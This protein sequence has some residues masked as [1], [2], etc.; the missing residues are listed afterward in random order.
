MIMPFVIRR[1]ELGAICMTRGL[2]V[3][4]YPRDILP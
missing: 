2:R 3:Q 4:A 1:I